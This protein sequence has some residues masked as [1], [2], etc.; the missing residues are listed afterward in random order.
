MAFNANELVLERIR[1]VEEYDPATLELTGRY[2]QI[3]DPKL[4]F[5]TDSTD[6]VD[7]MGNSVMTFY[8]AKKGTFDFSNS[9]FSLDLAASQFGSKKVIADEDNKITMPVSEVVTITADHKA[10][11]TYVP[12]GT[13]NAE[14]KYVKVINNDNTFGKTY[15]I[16]ALAGEGK[17]TLDAKTKTITLPDDVTGKVFVNYN[18]ETSTAVKVSNSTDGQ[19]EVKTLLIHAIFHPICNKNQL[20]AGVIRCPRAQ[21]NP[22]SVDINLTSDGKH[23]AS[24][25]LQ[26][27]YCADDANLVDIIVSED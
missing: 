18:K 13:E 4:S 22:E 3:E 7:A 20:I 8:K 17:F 2:T 10:V 6:V 21:I 9:F 24:Y 19:P 15:E 12:V 1:T 23:A 11:L 14:I 25:I 27:D 16:S 5:S 26:K